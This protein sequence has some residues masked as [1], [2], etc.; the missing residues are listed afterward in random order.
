M[1]EVEVRMSGNLV[2]TP[3]MVFGKNGKAITKFVIVHNHRFTSGGSWQTEDVGTFMD[4]VVFDKLAEH[5]MESLDKG[6]RVVVYGRL[7]PE[8]WL[9][10]EGRK[11]R[12]FKLIADDVGVSL[13]WGPVEVQ[14][15]ERTRVSKPD[16]STE[17]A[18]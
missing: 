5:C 16:Y 4:V 3:D 1:P 18:L 17:E 8:E 2:R 14:R 7:K 12:G 13:K 6:D 15:N 11:Q 9:D 10:S